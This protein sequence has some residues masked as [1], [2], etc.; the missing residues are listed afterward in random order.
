VAIPGGQPV[1]ISREE[2][3]GIRRAVERTVP[4]WTRVVLFGSRTD[5]A[6]RGGDIDLLVEVGAGGGIGAIERAL[7]LAMEDEIGEQKVDVVIDDGTRAD[8]F[9][10]LA[11]ERGVVLWTRD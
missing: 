11:R 1:R 10:A 5:P 8:S 4:G 9:I 2:R 6:A 3:E 7:R